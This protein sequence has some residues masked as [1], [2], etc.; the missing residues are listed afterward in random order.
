MNKIIS[1]LLT[2]SLTFAMAV[3]SSAD[4]IESPAVFYGFIEENGEYASRRDLLL[5]LSRIL[6]AGTDIDDY[7]KNN[8]IN[9]DVS[10]S[11]VTDSDGMKLLKLFSG[12][13]RFSDVIVFNGKTNG[14]TSRIAALDE[15]ITYRDVMAICLRF[16]KMYN[17]GGY[18]DSK[19]DDEIIRQETEKHL[20]LTK[21]QIKYQNVEDREQR[22][23]I[24]GISNDFKNRQDNFDGHVKTEELIKIIDLLL[25]A[26][27]EVNCVYGPE[28]QY[29][30]GIYKDITEE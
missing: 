16:L 2:I 29:I 15:P 19:Y 1:V 12:K 5:C 7:I 18:I 14:K 24:I 22:E 9:T 20:L 6:T 23:Y 21:E 17:T 25:F 27:L 28:Y 11:D 3:N 30:L 13:V 4:N 10:F 8:V 26:P